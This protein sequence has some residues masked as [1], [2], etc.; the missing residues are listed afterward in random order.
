MAVTACSSCAGAVDADGYCEDCGR[1]A[2]DPW[3][4][5]EFHGPGGAVGITWKGRTHETN[6]DALALGGTGGWTAAVVCDGVS[7]APGSGRAARLACWAAQEAL[8]ATIDAGAT[9]SALDTAW[10]A[11][12]DAVA[13]LAAGERSPACTFCAAIVGTDG[14]RVAWSG[15]TRAYWLPDVGPALLLTADDHDAQGRLTAWLGA[16]S[17][18]EGPSTGRFAPVSGGL[19][20]LASDGFTR[21]TE[22]AAQVAAVAG[23]GSSRTRADRM[24]AH[25][26]DAG[27]LDDITLIAIPVERNPS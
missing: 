18:T 15:D 19:L 26:V 2:P 27:G 25:A 23:L 9:E 16:D 6:E 8:I 11:A 12:Q 4:H 21:Y 10:R 1:R 20:V 17:T 7:S 5:R 3:D 14:I 24:L 22:D 13:G